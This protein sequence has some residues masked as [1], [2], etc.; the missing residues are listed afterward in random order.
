MKEDP[1][2]LETVWNIMMEDKG[3]ESMRAA[4]SLSIFTEK[5]P[6]RIKSRISEI[7]GSLAGIRSTSVRRSMLKMLTFLPLPEDQIG[8]LFDT[9]FDI[10]ESPSA[11]IGHKAYSMFILYNISEI[12]PELK[13][14]LVALFESQLDNESAGI[15]ARCITLINKLQKDLSLPGNDPAGN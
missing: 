15:R 7:T 11:E 9:C 8:I 6:E 12:E 4:W 2:V 14:E 3:K 1:A 13:P 5:H 10:V